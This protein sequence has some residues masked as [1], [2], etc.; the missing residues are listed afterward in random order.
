MGKISIQQL[1]KILDSEAGD[2]MS[3]K[4]I[5]EMRRWLTDR[6]TTYQGIAIM[7]SLLGI[8]IASLNFKNIFI[9]ISIGL[10]FLL[11]GIMEILKYKATKS[12]EVYP[13]MYYERWILIK[14]EQIR[15]IRKKYGKRLDIEAKSLLDF[16][17]KDMERSLELARKRFSETRKDD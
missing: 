13:A 7:V 2:P 17:E 14:M 12:F 6:Y 11:V 1:N 4:D 16:Y 10:I 15:K 9:S 5:V 8:L 3:Y